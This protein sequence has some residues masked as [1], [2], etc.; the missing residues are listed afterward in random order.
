[1]PFPS[2]SHRYKV[3]RPLNATLMTLLLLAGAANLGSPA[4]LPAQEPGV[5][6]GVVTRTGDDGPLP[7]VRVEL[8]EE[9]APEATDGLV[10]V[11]FT[12][13]QGQFRL[14]PVPPGSYTL[15]LHRMGLRTETL[16]VTVDAEASTQVELRMEDE[17]LPVAGITVSASGQMQRVS[18][19]AAAVGVL[20]GDRLR[21]RRGGHP[22]EIMGQIPG[23]LVNT[24]GGEGHMTAIRQPLTTDPVYLFLEDGIPTRSTGFFNHNALYEVNLPQADGVEVIRGPG[25]ALYGSDAIGGV[26][27][28]RTRPPSTDPQAELGVEG[29]EFGWARLLASAS[30][31]QDR[32]GLRADLNLTTSDGWREATAYERQSGTLRWDRSLSAWT[33]FRT[34]ATFSRIEQETAG[35]SP[36]SRSDYE[37][38]PRR[39][40]TP[41]SYRSVRALRLSSELRHSTPQASWTLTPF[42]RHNRM[43][44]L[45]DWALTFDPGIWDT[46]NSSVGLLSRVSAPVRRL[47]GDMVAGLDLDL[48]P[49][50]RLE[51]RIRPI[52][53]DGVFTDFE[54]DEAVYDYDVTFAQLAPYIQARTRPTS[55]LR[56]EAGLRADLLQYRYEST[57][58][59]LQEG[60]HRRPDDTRVRYAHLSPKLGVTLDARDDLN[61]FASYRH[62][63]R[64]PSESQLF[65]QGPAE[66][67]TGLEPVKTHSL[68]VGIRGRVGRALSYELTGYHMPK[69]DDIVT[70][71][72]PDGTPETQNAGKT[73]HRGLEAGVQI[74]PTEWARARWAYSW[75]R[76]TYEEWEPQE[77]LNLAGNQMEFAPQESGSM[78][79]SLTP[80]ALEGSRISL[81]WTRVGAYWMDPGNS[82]EYE[83]HDLLN[84]R[85]DL[86]LPAGLTAYGRLTNLTDERHAERASFNQFRGAELAPGRPRALVIGVEWR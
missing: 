21:A 84:L 78:E 37:S 45:P 58:P 63:F 59:A 31:T 65:R 2:L 39:N 7:G 48:S 10:S 49:G 18:E 47:N 68:E 81:E 77:G 52:Q 20:Q 72:R 8:R 4:S 57:L 33:G 14:S 34:V 27:D 60:P 46:Q 23:V 66:N 28:V 25:T 64:A 30:G 38:N 12:D 73:L 62:G 42:L 71:T 54:E 36:L 61:L 74:Q 85:L 11:G 17:A 3:P 50:S 70:F 26:I 56:L 44:L 22:S 43:E 15:E 69:S 19:T 79:V 9:G 13:G 40:V 32:N 83:G 51:R 55:R 41:I 75:A 29:G 67:T 53:S 76:H 24:T 1:M 6:E 5:V 35:T 82:E 16:A 86:P 80:P